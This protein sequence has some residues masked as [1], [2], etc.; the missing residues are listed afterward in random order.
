MPDGGMIGNQEPMRVYIDD[1]GARRK[2]ENVGHGPAVDEDEN[3]SVV[4]WEDLLLDA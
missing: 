3:V 1:Q 2:A 4:R